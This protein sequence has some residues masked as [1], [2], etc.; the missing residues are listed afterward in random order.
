M[1]RSTACCAASGQVPDDVAP[2]PGTCP[3]CG[4]T[5]GCALVS[6]GE[7]AA[8]CWC[9]QGTFTAE[10]LASVPLVAQGKACICRSCAAR[11]TAPLSLVAPSMT[12]LP[13]YIAA[14]ERDWSAD[15]MRPDAAAE[16][17]ATIRADAE[18]FV[19]Q[20]TRREPGG[21]TVTL[22]D[23]S[24]VPHLPGYKR[25]LWDGEFC[26]LIGLRWQTGTHD[27]PPYCLGH[28]GY[29]VVPWKQRRG[30]ATAA[31]RLLLPQAGAEGLLYVEI[32]TDPSNV[33][34]QRVVEANGGVL[35]ERFTRP[36]QFGATP[37]LRYRIRLA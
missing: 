1:S 32:T 20:Q 28:I 3:L 34:S 13:G 11:G 24:Q 8:P 6:G 21:E 15:N 25:W 7:S 37:G 5:N 27:L 2:S 29:S 19:A 33:A 36:A 30:Y 16:E 22:P 23:G 10:L 31:L 26:G 9:T 35:H 14:L 17:L 18:R 4:E 12:H